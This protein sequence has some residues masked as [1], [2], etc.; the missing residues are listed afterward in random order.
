MGQARARGTHSERVAAAVEAAKTNPP[1]KK[2]NRTQIRA[3]AM[4]VA[5]EIMGDI[6]TGRRPL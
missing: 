2:L 3:R 1:A 4:G 5:V 6:L